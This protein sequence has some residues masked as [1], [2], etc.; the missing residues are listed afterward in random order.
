M[1]HCTIISWDELEENAV[2]VPGELP[3]ASSDDEIVKH[4]REIYGDEGEE[5]DGY[6]GEYGW[7][8]VSLTRGQRTANIEWRS[9]RNHVAITTIVWH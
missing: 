8:L 1:L 2:A 3:I 7:E 5:S 6:N 4:I 9:D